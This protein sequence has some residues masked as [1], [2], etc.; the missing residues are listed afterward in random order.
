MTALGGLSFIFHL[1]I[2]WKKINS[3]DK[4][5]YF[6]FFKY[7]INVLVD[8]SAILPRILYVKYQMFEQLDLV[9][10]IAQFFFFI[11]TFPR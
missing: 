8:I 7:E 1:N 3:K 5:V 10:K 4:I 2:N 9:Q 6:I 11:E